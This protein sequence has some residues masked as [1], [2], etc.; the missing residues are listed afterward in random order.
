M[1]RNTL[2]YLRFWCSYIP[3]GMR[4]SKIRVC[5]VLLASPPPLKS[6]P[7]YKPYKRRDTVSAVAVWTV[8]YDKYA[9]APTRSDF[10]VLL[11][12]TAYK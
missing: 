7:C 5:L 1:L 12:S 11:V 2:L 4:L 6:E 3:S 10:L 8:E 9:S